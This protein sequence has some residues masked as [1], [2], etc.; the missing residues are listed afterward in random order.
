MVS[1]THGQSEGY[2][3]LQ[4]SRKAGLEQLDAFMPK[5]QAYA[6]ERNFDRPQQPTVSYLSAYL[7]YRLITEEEVICAVIAEH[8]LDVARKFVEEIGWRVYFK[9]HLEQHPGIWRAFLSSLDQ[10]Q[11]TDSPSEWGQLEQARNGKTGI[12]CMDHWLREI[13]RTGYLHNHA[14][15][16]FASIWIFTLK[17]PWQAG[18]ALFLDNLVDADAASN[19]LSWRWVAGLHTRGKAYAARPELIRRYSS[20]GF[21]PVRQLAEDIHPLDWDGPFCEEPLSS[22]RILHSADS[23]DIDHCPAG[24]LITPDDLSVEHS[25]LSVSPFSSVAVFSAQVFEGDAQADAN[26][27]ARQFVDGA[28]LDAGSRAARCWEGELIRIRGHVAPSERLNPAENVGCNAPLRVYAGRVDDWAESVLNWA[29]NEN[30]NS[31]WMM[32]PPVGPWRDRVGRLRS[33]L[34]R[35]GIRLVEFRRP[36]DQQH[37]PYARKGYFSFRENFLKQAF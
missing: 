23:P 27:P 29:A 5:V 18:A 19:T 2:L 1:Q 14:R 10:A 21:H 12:E 11:S 26:S 24:L 31:I 17:L 9:G 20:R 6:Q 34:L 15:M 13:R 36:F 37:W 28:V 22:A 8:G 30:L 16:S 33:A 3:Q 35:R 25:Q 32:Q 7:R 4:P